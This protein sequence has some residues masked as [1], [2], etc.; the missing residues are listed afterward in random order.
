MESAECRGRTGL[1]TEN[2]EVDARMG[3]RSVGGAKSLAHDERSRFMQ[4]PAQ[5][6][7]NG[8]PFI[9]QN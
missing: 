3:E 6:F 2:F 7:T 9:A 1:P 4:A 5:L 8:R